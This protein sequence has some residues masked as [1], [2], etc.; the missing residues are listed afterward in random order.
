MHLRPILLSCALLAPAAFLA[1][2]SAPPARSVPNIQA[3]PVIVPASA[4]TEL[5]LTIY[6]DS[7]NGGYAFVRESR[8][9]RLPAGRFI[10]KA[11]DVASGIVPQTTRFELATRDDS[12]WRG[13]GELYE[14]QYLYD[15]LGVQRL[16]QKAE[17]QRVTLS[18]WAGGRQGHEQTVSGVVVSATGP[19][20]VIRA[21]NGELFSAEP[22]Q[23]ISLASL[24]PDLVEKPTLQWK[25]GSFESCDALLRLSYRAGDFSWNADYVIAFDPATSKADVEGWVTVSN[26]GDTSFDAAKLQVAAGKVHAIPVAA[27]REGWV[28]APTTAALTPAA[29]AAHA[30][31]ETLGELHLYT[32]EHPTD[33]PARSSKQ[34]RF[35]LARTEPARLEAETRI[36]AQ[37]GAFP[38]RLMLRFEHPRTGPLGV[39]LP[40]GEARTSVTALRGAT[41]LVG[42]GR[43]DHTPAGEPWRVP[44]ETDANQITRVIV[45]NMQRLGTDASGAVARRYDVELQV[46]NAGRSPMHRRLIFDPEGQRIARLSTLAGLKLEG[47]TRAVLE[48]DLAPQQ[49]KS[50]R[51]TVD[52]VNPAETVPKPDEDN[53][54]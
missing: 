25:V 20:L 18:R 53:E 13:A 15:Q 44:M 45:R 30:T 3:P 51:L 37:S 7:R 6:S 29:S 28:D 16:L 39:P 11:P 2:R 42:T 46:R 34:V 4:R 10:L 41:V 38:A 8:K 35:V 48:L 31:E 22:F 32:I 54:P 23:R 27:T 33:L 40:A 26:L 1:C 5:A 24:P 14:Q 52:L 43:V 47:P 12:G 36:T 21:D 9:V 19:A 49:H 50:F 17:G